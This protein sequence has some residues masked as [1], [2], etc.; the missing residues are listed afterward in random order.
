MQYVPVAVIVLLVDI[1]SQLQGHVMIHLKLF[2]RK[3][4]Y[5]TNYFFKESKRKAV[6]TFL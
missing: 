4:N 1:I 2:T 3:D 5:S 6:L